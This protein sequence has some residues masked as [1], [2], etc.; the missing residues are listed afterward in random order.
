MVAN[1]ADVGL[2]FALPLL[3]SVIVVRDSMTETLFEVLLFLF[4]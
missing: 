4:Y 2:Q 1:F 3:R